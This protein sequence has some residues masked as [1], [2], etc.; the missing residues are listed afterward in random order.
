MIKKFE[1]Y[2]SEGFWKDSIKRTKSNKKR[3]E[4]MTMIDKL[5]DEICHIMSEYMGIEYSP[6]LCFPVPKPIMKTK[7]FSNVRTW[8]VSYGSDVFYIKFNLS[9]LEG[10]DDI[11][12]EFWLRHKLEEYER[13]NNYDR[14]KKEALNSL[15]ILMGDMTSKGDFEQELNLLKYIIEKLT[16]E[17]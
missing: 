15:K 2:I 17:I 1:E 13:Q 3:L 7:P 16:N 5:C 11:T 10:A 8:K 14:L 6:D 9:E 12:W 4:D